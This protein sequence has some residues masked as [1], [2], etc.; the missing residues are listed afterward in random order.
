VELLQRFGIPVLFRGPHP[1]AKKIWIWN[2]RLFV[3][4]LWSQ[5]GLEIQNQSK[6]LLKIY[7]ATFRNNLRHWE[8]SWDQTSHAWLDNKLRKALRDRPMRTRGNWTNGA[9]TIMASGLQQSEQFGSQISMERESIDGDIMAADSIGIWIA[10]T[11][12]NKRWWK[13]SIRFI[14]MLFELPQPCLL[15][16]IESLLNQWLS[17]SQD[18]DFKWQIKVLI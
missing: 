6:F 12:Q 15:F 8:K 16:V 2:E 17:M 4:Q 14:W 3:V 11:S 9:V 5:F 18:L 7:S 1:S 10:D 13:H